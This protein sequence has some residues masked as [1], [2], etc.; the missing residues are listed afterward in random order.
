MEIIKIVRK[1]KSTLYVGPFISSDLLSKHLRDRGYELQN[2][3][4][5]WHKFGYA[6][7]QGNEKMVIATA[8]AMALHP[9]TVV[10]F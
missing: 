7:D 8:T 6:H 5:V 10:D 1:R 9:P 2:G 3:P 4:N